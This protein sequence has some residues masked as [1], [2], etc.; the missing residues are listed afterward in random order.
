METQKFT[1]TKLTG[2]G[3]NGY[4]K[5]LIAQHQKEITKYLTYLGAHHSDITFIMDLHKKEVTK[6]NI[7]KIYTHTVPVFLNY[8]LDFKLGELETFTTSNN[9][10]PAQIN[11]IKT[12][13]HR[14]I[15][16]KSKYINQA[17][18]KDLVTDFYLINQ[19]YNPIHIILK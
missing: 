14:F 5:Y 16:F 18:Y 12:N 15:N 11:N 6:D 1:K 13:T 10:K 17:P 3:Q 9:S 2:L 4:E 8:L 19:G 7:I